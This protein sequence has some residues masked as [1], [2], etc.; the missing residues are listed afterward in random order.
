V[1]NID[2]TAVIVRDYEWGDATPG[3]GPVWPHGQLAEAYLLAGMDRHNLLALLVEATRALGLVGDCHGC[4]HNGWDDEDK[5][6]DFL[7]NLPRRESAWGCRASCH[8]SRNAAALS[9]KSRQ[10]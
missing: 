4:L 1:K 7:E 6:Y 9:V 8:A 10:T 3:S 5:L 2:M